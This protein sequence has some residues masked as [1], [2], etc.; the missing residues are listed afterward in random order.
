MQELDQRLLVLDVPPHL[1][2]LFTERPQFLLLLLLLL[3]MMIIILVV[4]IVFRVEKSNQAGA[5]SGYLSIYLS[6]S[7]FTHIRSPVKQ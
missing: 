1:A 3:F 4:V 7:N 5:K 2:V 6:I